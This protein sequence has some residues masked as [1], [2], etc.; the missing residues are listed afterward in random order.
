MYLWQG[1]PA[2]CEYGGYKMLLFLTENRTFGIGM[3]ELLLRRGILTLWAKHDAGAALC[4]RWDVCGAVLDG[5]EDLRSAEAVCAA[6]RQSEPDMPIALLLPAGAIASCDADRLIRE[7]GQDAMLREIA[8]FCTG[9]CGWRTQMSTYAL[10]IGESP[11]ET[12]Y[13]GYPLRLAQRELSILRFLFYRAPQ[14]VTSAEL[15]S[16]CFPE[17]T[18]RAANLSVQIGRINRRAE[19]AAGLP[20]IESVYG[21]G[22]RL[23]GGIVKKQKQA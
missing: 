14:T 5:Q 17:N 3:T 21:K 22:Y 19:E 16:V 23:C 2:V 15:L 12:R 20:L 8:S 1:H 9:T 7:S 13:L 4:G 11:A 10:T 18:Q 6:L